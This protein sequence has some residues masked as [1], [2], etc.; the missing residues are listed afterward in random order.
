MPRSSPTAVWRWAASA[1][2]VA[3]VVAAGSYAAW[4]LTRG[5]P[6]VPT[7]RIMLAVLPFQN[8][9]GDPEQ[10]YLCDGLTEEMIAHLGGVDPVATR[11][12]RAHIG[13]ALQ[14]HDEAG[15]RN[16]AGA[17]RQYLLETS[18]RTN[19]QPRSNHGAAHRRA[20]AKSCLGGT[21]RA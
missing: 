7:T 11:G 1:V 3:I 13:D 19:R 20:D 16:R 14:G 8:L 6:I 18:L 2:G 12:H 10:Q 5:R 9:T 4:V 21:V 15:R 17:R